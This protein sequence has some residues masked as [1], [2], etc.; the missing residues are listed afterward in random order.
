M[1]NI[2]GGN[3]PTL[4]AQIAGDLGISVD[5]ARALIRRAI[6]EGHS[7]SDKN[8]LTIIGGY[9]HGPPGGDQPPTVIQP[10][11]SGSGSGGGGG[12]ASGPDPAV[13]RSNYMEILRSWGIP[14]DD[15]GNLVDSAVSN[16]WSTLQFMQAVR[17]TKAYKQNFS[18]IASQP[19]MSE[20]SYLAQYRQYKAL[21][22][23]IGKK[24]TRQQFGA[25]LKGGVDYKEWNF[26]VQGVQRVQQNQAVFKWYRQELIKSGELKKGQG[27]PFKKMW[28]ITTKL[29]SVDFERV[30]ERAWLQG[31]LQKIGFDLT[32]AGGRDI[33]RKRLLSL[34]RQYESGTPGAEVEAFGAQQFQ[35]L[36]EQ[37]RTTIPASQLYG[38]GISKADLL[39]MKL[40]GRRAA[41]I[42]ER[43]QRALNQAKAESEDKV[44]AQLVQTEKGTTMLGG[45]L[46]SE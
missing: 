42:A 30:Y 20:G 45:G 27:L 41:S 46:S 35:E 24:L 39:E 28:E 26:R 3:A 23:D 21:A 12:G 8:F 36:A 11:G 1:P 43:A 9:L 16:E 18:G 40:G 2:G 7:P 17:R 38:Y 13:L 15:V 6:N 44:T 4:A 5:R 37:I 22:Q 25:L 14:A 34:I 29:N 10:G 33:S 31:N 32:K 19:G